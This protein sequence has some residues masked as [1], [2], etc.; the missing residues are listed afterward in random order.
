MR[1]RSAPHRHRKSMA[2]INRGMMQMHPA[3]KKD[4]AEWR[5]IHDESPSLGSFT[6]VSFRVWGEKKGRPGTFNRNPWNRRFWIL[7]GQFFCYFNDDNSSSKCGGCI[8]VNAASVE[9]VGQFD[10]HNNCIRVRPTVPRRPALPIDSE[11]NVWIISFDSPADLEKAER[12]RSTFITPAFYRSYCCS[13]VF[14]F[15]PFANCALSLIPLTLPQ[16]LTGA[17]VARAELTQAPRARGL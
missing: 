11:D 10:Q 1:K 8:Y 2:F 16:T 17:A 3:A 6:D 14:L 12:A 15:S 4:D 9:N 5:R 13:L 7:S